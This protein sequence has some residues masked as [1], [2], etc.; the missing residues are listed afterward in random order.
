L[1]TFR[2]NTLTVLLLFLASTAYGALPARPAGPVNDFAGVIEPAEAGTLTQILTTLQQQT[3]I[4]MVIVTLPTLEG[5]DI[6][7]TATDLFQKWGIGEK[8][9]D[10]GILILAAI[11]DRDAR[12]EVGYG[13][14]GAI[15]DAFAGRILREVLFPSF[16]QS[17]YG[18]GLLKGAVVLIKRLEEKMGFSLETTMPE[19]GSLRAPMPP[20]LAWALRILLFIGL[21]YLFIRHPRL[22]LFLLWMSGGRGRNDDDQ[23]GG[24]GGFG[25]GSS[26]GGGA[27]G[28][29]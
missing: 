10:N 17:R 3:G 20:A 18:E 11:Q 4:A 16:R 21:A 25:G 2:L 26:G 28:K 13:L 9:K 24:F 27:S 5:S 1:R 15:P 6:E 12:I 23:G 14:E 19:V 29:W 7:T 22:L 8:G